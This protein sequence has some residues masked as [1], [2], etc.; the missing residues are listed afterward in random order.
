[1]TLP[2]LL[3][4][5]Q[6]RAIRQKCHPNR[7]GALLSAHRKPLELYGRDAFP[8]LYSETAKIFISYIFGCRRRILDRIRLVTKQII[9]IEGRD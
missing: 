6:E 7:E 1:M 8:V 4:L 2:N 3:D 9:G 5:K